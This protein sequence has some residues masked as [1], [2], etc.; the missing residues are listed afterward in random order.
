MNPFFL[1]APGAG[2]PS[3]HPWMQKWKQSLEGHPLR[4]RLHAGGAKAARSASPTYRRASIRGDKLGK[5]IGPP[6]PLPHVVVI[7]ED[8]LPDFVSIFASR[9]ELMVRLPLERKG[10]RGS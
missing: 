2:A 1:F 9:D 6:S 5:R 8:D 4:L 3:T 7:E 10:R